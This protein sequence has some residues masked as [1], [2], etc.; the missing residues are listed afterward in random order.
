[1]FTEPH[2]VLPHVG[3]VQPTQVPAWHVALPVHDGHAMFPLPHAFGTLPQWGPASVASH[4]GGVAP[5]TPPMHCWPV[6]HAGHCFVSPQPSAIVPQSV[7]FGLGVHVSVPHDAPESPALA[8]L[9]VMGKHWFW[10]QACP[11]GHP[12]QPM[13]T[14]H[15]S[16]P[17]TPHLPVHDGAWH[18]CDVPVPMHAWPLGHGEPHAMV[19]PEHGSV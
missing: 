12:P 2:V 3:G 4:S 17:M 9:T 8:S 16:V 13:A 1:L 18:D 5:H 14:P 11:V 10:T 15:E 19:V 7:V 6:G